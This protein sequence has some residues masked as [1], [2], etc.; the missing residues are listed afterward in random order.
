M[1]ENAKRYV[2]SCPKCQRTRNISQR[3]VMPWITIYI[4]IYLKF[5]GL[6]LWG[7]SK[8][9]MDIWAHPSHGLLCIQVGRGHSMS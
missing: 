2:S 3:N 6:T 4:S 1:H 7:L 8:T 9:H 5:G